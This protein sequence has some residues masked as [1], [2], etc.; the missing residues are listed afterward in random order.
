MHIVH[1]H[2]D[3]HTLTVNTPAPSIHIS[4]LYNY[5]NAL[6][7]PL[8]CT[9]LQGLR[10]LYERGFPQLGHIQTGNV[11]IEDGQNG[12]VCVLGG[13]ENTLLGYKTRS[14]KLCKEHLESIDLLLFGRCGWVWLWVGLKMAL[15]IG[16][17]QQ[18][19]LPIKRRV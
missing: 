15:W 12:N 7:C 10:Y 19:C 14:Y 18:V 1:V 17:L 16:G 11:F 3:T 5:A 8:T 13:F 9:C 4:H 2:A 6:T